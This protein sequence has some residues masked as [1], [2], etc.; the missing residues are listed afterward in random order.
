MSEP[1][2]ELVR[3]TLICLTAEGDDVY[4]P[5]LLNAVGPVEHHRATVLRLEDDE[6][7]RLIRMTVRI[8]S[9]DQTATNEV[10]P[11]DL[12]HRAVDG[13]DPQ[14]IAYIPATDLWKWEGGTFN[15]PSGMGAF[16]LIRAVRGPHPDDGHEIIAL[17]VEDE[18]HQRRPILLETTGGMLSEFN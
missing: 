3:P 8:H 16:R 12:V 6:P 15:D 13:N 1:D 2:F 14:T 11:G 17:V 4:V 10:K 5:V 7:N 9:F 18:H